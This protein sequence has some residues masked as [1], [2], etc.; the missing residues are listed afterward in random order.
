MKTTSVHTYPPSAYQAP[1]P[2]QQNAPVD[3][4]RQSASRES[5]HERPSR[6]GRIMKSTVAWFRNLPKCSC[7]SDPGISPERS[8]RHGTPSN[9]SLPHSEERESTGSGFS[10]QRRSSDQGALPVAYPAR[11]LEERVADLRELG[12]HLDTAANMA[13]SIRP[14]KTLG[15]HPHG[16]GSRTGSY[17]SRIATLGAVSRRQTGASF[18]PVQLSPIPESPA[19]SSP[20]AQGGVLAYAGHTPW[21][22]P[23]GM[24]PPFTPSLEGGS[25]PSL[26]P[27]SWT[28]ANLPDARLSRRHVSDSQAGPQPKDIEMRPMSHRA[29]RKSAREDLRYMPGMT[30]STNV[31]TNP[32]GGFAEMPA[33]ASSS[34]VYSAFGSGQSI[35]SLASPEYFAGINRQAANEFMQ[36]PGQDPALDAADRRRIETRSSLR[37]QLGVDTILFSQ[38]NNQNSA[39]VAGDILARRVLETTLGST[40]VEKIN[41][42][43]SWL[44][45]TWN[46]HQQVQDAE[47]SPKGKSSAQNVDQLRNT[48]REQL[49]LF[50]NMCDE[51]NILGF[52]P[53]CPRPRTDDQL[54]QFIRSNRFAIL[55][56]AIQNVYDQI[57][58][59]DARGSGIEVRYSSASS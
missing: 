22:S 25:S 4:V 43:M 12:R 28:P 49:R 40:N 59:A 54:D 38:I 51:G 29:S 26:Y 37:R 15:L 50:L 27:P 41:T 47:E 11:T 52:G 33:N 32:A 18:L 42:W 1:R 45:A 2:E 13:D 3:S 17:P 58:N 20:S 14:P 31:H 53:G 48:R 10:V 6:A 39:E 34:S 24:T 44:N 55:V 8:P 23:A 5:E 21:A 35:T 16:V 36:A 7:V 19:A 9:I 30:A 46:I 56:A 57:K